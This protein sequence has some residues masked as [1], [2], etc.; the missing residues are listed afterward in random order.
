MPLTV[1]STDL[2]LLAV[3]VS[4]TQIIAVKLDR[5]FAFHAGDRFG[6]IVLQVLREIEFHAGKFI[7]QLGQ[8]L[9]SQYLLVMG[10]RPLACRFQWSEEF[11]IEQARG[12]GAVVG[13]AMLR[14]HRLPLRDGCE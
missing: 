12:V 3:S 1:E 10:V 7:L 4:A 2:I 14:N 8:Q 9:R 13:T 6:N 5:V 11:G